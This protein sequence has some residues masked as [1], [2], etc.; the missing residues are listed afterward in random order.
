MAVSLGPGLFFCGDKKEISDRIATVRGAAL[1]TRVERPIEA[2]GHNIDVVKLRKQV[3]DAVSGIAAHHRH[4]E[5]F[6]QHRA[7]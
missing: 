6:D 2:A 1:I 7:E 3:L 5:S 4:T